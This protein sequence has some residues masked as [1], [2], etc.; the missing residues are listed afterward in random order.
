MP[1]TKGVQKESARVEAK[2]E[3]RARRGEEVLI[4]RRLMKCFEKWTQMVIKTFQRK[5]FLPLRGLS[6]S[7]KIKGIYFLKDLMEMETV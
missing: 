6:V 7:L 3:Q 4:W 2:V 1:R 5:N